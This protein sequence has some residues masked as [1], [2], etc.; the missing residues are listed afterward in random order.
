MV[1]FVPPARSCVTCGL[2]VPRALGRHDVGFFLVP[3][4]RVCVAV[5][6][7]KTLPGGAELPVSAGTWP[8]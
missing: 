6:L 4:A 5:V 7:K 1:F 2:I 8:Q 3:R